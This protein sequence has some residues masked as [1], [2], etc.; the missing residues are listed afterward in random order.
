PFWWRVRAAAGGRREARVLWPGL[1]L[2]QRNAWR[3]R[4]FILRW[5]RSDHHTVPGEQLDQGVVEDSAHHGRAG[6]AEVDPADM[7]RER[8]GDDAGRGEH[9]AYRHCGPPGHERSDVETG[10]EPVDPLPRPRCE[11]LQ[12]HWLVPATSHQV[13]DGHDP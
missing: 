1:Y 4:H 7:R 13:T 6:E 9:H 5:R 3:H 11:G 8:P 10:R 12:I 2:L